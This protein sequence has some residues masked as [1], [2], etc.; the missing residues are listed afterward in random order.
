MY[1]AAFSRPP[2]EDES[3]A[4]VDFLI[5]QARAADKKPD[6]PAVWA[7]LAH[8]LFNVKEFIYIH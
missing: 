6:D 5:S 8:T 1:E 3:A 2:T 7:D 4:C